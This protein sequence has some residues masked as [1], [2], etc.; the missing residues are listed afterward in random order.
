MVGSG[1]QIVRVRKTAC[2]SALRHGIWVQQHSLGSVVVL[3][4]GSEL[5]QV[6]F[7]GASLSALPL[8]IECNVA[9]AGHREEKVRLHFAG[10]TVICNLK[11]LVTRI[12][13]VPA[14]RKS[15][16]DAATRYEN[17]PNCTEIFTGFLTASSFIGEN[18]PMIEKGFA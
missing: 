5:P 2:D 15:T 18:T 6:P 14:T 4:V 16:G 12:P 17:N 8:D 1:R 13:H 3:R 11:Y 10:G 7:L 9:L